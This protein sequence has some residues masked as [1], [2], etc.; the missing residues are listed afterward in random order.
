MQLT[1]WLLVEVAL[2]L[3]GLTKISLIKSGFDQNGGLKESIFGYFPENFGFFWF[4][5]VCYTTD[6]FV[7]VVSISKHRNKPKSLVFGFTKQT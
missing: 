5:S 6:P 3:I 1:D 7:S 4:V 2:L